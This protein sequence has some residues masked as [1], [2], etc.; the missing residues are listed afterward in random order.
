MEV[1]L[2]YKINGIIFMFFG[3]GCWLFYYKRPINKMNNLT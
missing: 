3:V 1:E 2:F